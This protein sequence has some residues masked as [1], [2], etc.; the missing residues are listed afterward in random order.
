MAALRALLQL[1]DNKSI[2]TIKAEPHV[3]FSGSDK[4]PRGRA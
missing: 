1:A 3:G 4:N 2:E